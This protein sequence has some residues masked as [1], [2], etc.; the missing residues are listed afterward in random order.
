MVIWCLIVWWLNDGASKRRFAADHF[1]WIRSGFWQ[2]IINP[3]IWTNVNKLVLMKLTTNNSSECHGCETLLAT[4]PLPVD[5]LCH[6]Q[7]YTYSLHHGLFQEWCCLHLDSRS[8][9]STQTRNWMIGMANRRWIAS[10]MQGRQSV[11]SFGVQDLCT[12]KQN[13]GK[14]AWILP[15]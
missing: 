14:N 10:Q 8:L 9:C 5:P 15:E 13:S 3:K 4:L 6:C 1:T 12:V 2:S 11:K 7:R